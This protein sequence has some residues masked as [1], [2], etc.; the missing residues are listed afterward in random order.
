[1]TAVVFPAAHRRGGVER[2]A[3]E[4]LRHSPETC[5]VFVGGHL[6][7]DDLDRD[8]DHRPVRVSSGP[9]GSVQFRIASAKVLRGLSERVVSLGANCAPGDVKI[10]NSVHRAWLRQ[11]RPVRV[12]GYD[13]P[14]RIRYLLPQHRA[15]LTLE[16]AYFAHPCD[17]VIAVS[18]VVASDLVLLYDVP[19][20][21]IEV[22]P[23]GF[24]P[25]QCNPT[26]RAELR[27]QTRAAVGATE[28][29]VVLLF[30]ANELHRKGLGV[31]LEAVARL[32]DRRF[33]VDVV[34]RMPLD[35]F[36]SQ[37]D[38]LGLGTRV[39]HHGPVEDIGLAH[40]IADVLVLPTQY[41]AFA[42]TIVEAMASGLPVIT[43][44]VP[45]AGDRISHGVSGWIQHD[46]IDPAELEVLLTLASEESVRARVGQSGAEAVRD[47]TWQALTARLWRLIG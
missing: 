36:R 44:S 47:L 13:V 33:R 1:M 17:R 5:P 22:V 25:L 46:P 34:G 24:D 31:L 7:A 6:D 43:T 15:L 26:R 9:A 16:R 29:D 28:E 2:I 19:R 45:G 30:V 10:V 20:S 14:N 11:G 21:T 37:I 18:E 32:R 38:A 40:A 42:L 27:I 39:H 23:N 41:E 4:L 3:W 35:A 12:A 8:V